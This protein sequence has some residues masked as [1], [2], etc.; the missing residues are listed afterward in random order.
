MFLV[1]EHEYTMYVISVNIHFSIIS[2]NRS[3]KDINDVIM[4]DRIYR[5]TKLRLNFKNMIRKKCITEMHLLN[6]FG[7]SNPLPLWVACD[8]NLAMAL[9]IL[10]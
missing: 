1:N 2:I 6:V 3:K 9:S 8:T 4:L 7:E 10:T 5:R